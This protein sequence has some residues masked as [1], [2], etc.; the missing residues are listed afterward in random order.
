MKV[1]TGSLYGGLTAV[2]AIMLSSVDLG[3]T[4]YPVDA[5]LLKCRFGEGVH[6]PKLSNAQ[7]IEFT[8]FLETCTIS[9]YLKS[10]IRI[11]QAAFLKSSHAAWRMKVFESRTCGP[12]STAMK[13]KE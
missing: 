8:I 5:G 12:L 1:Y 4:V 11:G 7:V 6:S 10:F 2:A 9:A 13:V 3:T